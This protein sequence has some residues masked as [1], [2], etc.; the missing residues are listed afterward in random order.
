MEV[1]SAFLLGK[2]CLCSYHPS[3]V[4]GGV[5]LTA[6]MA[7]S[8]SNFGKPIRLSSLSNVTDSQENQKQ[9]GTLYSL[10]EKL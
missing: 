6:W 9:R 5:F 10:Y 4:F 8:N 2:L 1:E 3:R 7:E